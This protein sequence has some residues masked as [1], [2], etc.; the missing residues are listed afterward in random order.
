MHKWHVRGFR[1]D[2]F[3]GAIVS[4]PSVF[5]SNKVFVNVG[6]W[7]TCSRWHWKMDKLMVY[8]LRSFV[9]ILCNRLSLV[10][11]IITRWDYYKWTFYRYT[12]VSFAPYFIYIPNSRIS[13]WI[14]KLMQNEKIYAIDVVL[15]S[16]EVYE[17]EW[18]TWS[19]L[20]REFASRCWY[21]TVIQVMYVA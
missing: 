12:S 6:L 10:G 3:G 20:R 13:F 5:R 2:G 1:D 18:K 16:L 19:K 14:Y 21:F 7:C 4:H 8:L 15:L 11:V 9:Y 17:F